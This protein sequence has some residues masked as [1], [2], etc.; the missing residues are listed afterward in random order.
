M[1]RSDRRPDQLR[2]MVI[3][4]GFT[5]SAPGSVLI[6]AGRTKVLCTAS[7]LDQLPTWLGEAEQGWVTAEYSMLPGCGQPRKP[8]ER[9]G[10]IDG[11]SAEIQRL[12][13]RSLRAVTDLGALG[14]RTI[15][16]DCDVLEADGGTRTA[17][18]TG[19]WVALVD[20]VQSIA[21]ELPDQAHHPIRDSIAAVSTGI[22][23]DEL[24]LDLDYQE[25]AAAAVDLN[26]VMTGS[27]QL[28]EIQGTGERATFSQEQLIEMLQLARRGIEQ[29]TRLQRQVL[30]AD[31]PLSDT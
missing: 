7:V 3:H 27:G 29:I 11:R 23:E 6:E 9:G 26:V 2:P 13:G 15:I 20:A 19:A 30:G 25:D 22:V 18:I 10:R 1:R 21:S 5:S 17:S 14:R 8:R 31:W 24:L 4:R 16:V 28:A 12:V